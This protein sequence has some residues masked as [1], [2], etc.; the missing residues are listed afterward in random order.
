MFILAI[1]A[2]ICEQGR[3]EALKVAIVARLLGKPC[4][5]CETFINLNGRDWI[6][7]KY[8]VAMC[9]ARKIYTAH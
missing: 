1:T 3:P 8:S 7:K 5:Y 9:A 2:E 4:S 6:R